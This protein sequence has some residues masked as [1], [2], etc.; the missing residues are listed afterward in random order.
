MPLFNPRIILQKLG[1]RSTR[2]TWSMTL[3]YVTKTTRWWKNWTKMVSP[4]LILKSPT[5]HKQ[6]STIGSRRA[7]EIN[8]TINYNE[9]SYLINI[10]G[11]SKSF[12]SCQISSSVVLTHLLTVILNQKLQD[13]VGLIRECIRFRPISDLFNKSLSDEWKWAT[14]DS[15]R[16]LN[17]VTEPT[18]AG[19]QLLTNLGHLGSSESIRNYCIWLYIVFE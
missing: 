17:R 11:N 18:D 10:T 6:F 19:K 8:T 9:S 15:L 1:K 7:S 5:M 16:C 14:I 12:G 3:C 13:F 4:F 2:T